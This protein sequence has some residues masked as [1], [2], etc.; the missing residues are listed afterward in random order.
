MRKLIVVLFVLFSLQGFSQRYFAEIKNDTVQRVIVI[1]SAT[2]AN[3]LFGGT[4]VETFVD[5]IGKNY[6]GIGYRYHA[7]KK[8]FSAPRPFPSWTLDENLIWQPPTPM[9]TDGK[10]YYWKEETQEWLEIQ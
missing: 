2:L 4:W 1:E 8:N 5:S 6:A 9:P 10:I 7:D 3:Q